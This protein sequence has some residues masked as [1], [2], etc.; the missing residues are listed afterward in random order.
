MSAEATTMIGELENSLGVPT[1]AFL[2]HWIGEYAVDADEQVG[3]LLVTAMV[4]RLRREAASEVALVL[5]ARGGYPAFADAIIRAIDH[6]NLRLQVVLPTGVDGSM[7]LLALAADQVTVHAQAGV[8]A[9]DSGLCVTP[10]RAFDATLHEYCPVDPATLIAL[11]EGQRV[12]MARLAFDRQIRDE[13]RRAARRLVTSRGHD[14]SLVAR[15]TTTDLGCD[16]CARLGDLE[17]AGVAVRVAPDPLA[18]QLEDLVRWGESA[19]SLFRSPGERFQVSDELADEVQFEPATLVPAAAIAC[20]DRSWVHELDTGSPDPD[21]PK[22]L[23]QW[24]RWD[25][26]EEIGNKSL[27]I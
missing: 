4:E 2:G 22:L 8:G 10:R 19:L 24:R 14:A 16:L 25:L 11:D 17:A 3:R 26:A 12:E 21:A 23:G 7:S 9:V 27:S 18:E 15:F 1:F 13:Q 5:V 20:A 6:L